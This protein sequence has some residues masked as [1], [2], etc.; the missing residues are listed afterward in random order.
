MSR[1]ARRLVLPLALLLSA[2]A[3]VAQNH[4]NAD[5]G[6]APERA[7]QVG[8]IDNVSLF[9]GNLAI[10]IPLGG[11]YPAG[12]G[13]SY[14]LTLVYNSSVW[15]FQE[16]LTPEGSLTQA[17]PYRHSNAGFGWIVSLGRLYKPGDV[18]YDGQRW[19]YFGVDGAEHRFYPTLHEGD[20]E[21]AGD[22]SA[23]QKVQYS[24]EGSY[25]RLKVLAGGEHE[26]EFPDG[27][28]H[29]FGTDRKLKQIRDRFNN[30]VDVATTNALWT[31]TDGQG[32]IHRVHFTT[33]QYDT[34][35]LPT[36]DRVELQTFAGTATY[37]FGYS[38]TTVTRACPHNDT[39][40]LGTT[41][42]VPLLTSVSL[43]DDPGQAVS[44]YQYVM[45]VGDYLTTV[46]R[47]GPDCRKA[48]VLQGLRLPSRGRLEWSYQDYRF[49]TGS[50]RPPFQTTAGVSKRRMIDAGGALLGE[51]TYQTALT[52][53]QQIVPN[54]GTQ[55]LINTVID[56]LGHK[57]V[58]YFS[59]HATTTPPSDWTIEDYSL[60]FTRFDAGDGAGRFL[61]TRTFNSAGTLLRSTYVR[62][63]RDQ[64]AALRP[65]DFQDKL[66]LNRRPETERT[67]YHDDSNRFADTTFSEFDGLGNQRKTTTGGNF[68]EGNVRATT[69]AYNPARGIYE[70]DLASNAPAPGHTFT[71]LSKDSP[72]VLDTYASQKVEEAGDAAFATFCFDAGTGFLQRKRVLK[73]PTGVEDA[74]DLLEA[75]VP[76]TRPG[77]GSSTGDVASERFYGGDTQ[78]LATS[79]TLCSIGLPAVPSYQ[80]DHTYQFGVKAASQYA[81]TTFKVFDQDIHPSGLVTASRDSAGLAT[82]YEYD[83]QG[84][85]TW[86][87][88][89]QGHGGWTEYVYSPALSAGSLANVL[90]RQ[91]GNGIKTAPILVQS[92]VFVDAFGRL[93]R[94][95]QML[96]GGVWNTRETLYNASG[97]KKSDSELQVGNPTSV[98]Q[99]LDY[100]PFGR[101]QTI[102]PPDGTAHD[103]AFNYFGIRGVDRI[104]KVAVYEGGVVAEKPS[105]TTEV[106]DRQGR[107]VKV[108]EPSAGGTTPVPTLYTYDIGNRLKQVSTT[109]AGTTQNRFFNYDNRGFLTSE[110]HP[111][112]TGAVSYLLYDAR[113]HA[114]RK[115]DGPNDLALVYDKAER[116]TDVR[117]WSSN[118]LLKKLTYAGANGANDWRAG[119]LQEASRYNFVS[120]GATPYTVQIRES[121]TYGGRDGRVSRRDTASI[122]NGAAGDS[123]TQ[124]FSYNALGLPATVEYPICTHAGCGQPAPA[125]FTDVPQGHPAKKEIEAIYKAKVTLGCATNPARYC[126]EGSVTRAEMAL[127]LVRAAA[128]GD[129]VPPACGTPTFSDVPCGHWASAWIEE[130]YRRGITSGCDTNPL[131]YCPESWVA[132]PEMMIFLLR[133]KEGSTYTAPACTAPTF[134]D[135]TCGHWAASWIGEAA[136]RGITTGCGSGNFCP[137]GL[138]SRS[139]M[140]GYLTLAFDFPVVVDPL[141]PRTVQ[142]AY[143]Q[144]LL[145][146][147]GVPGNASLYGSLSYHPNLL[148][149][150]V[151]HGNGVVETQGNDPSAIRRPASLGASG[152]H[153]SWSS[154]PYSYD[155]ARNVKTI[156]T[157]WFG[158]DRVSRLTIGTV[159]DG[160][161]GGGS[162]KQQT[163]SFDPF[164]NLTAVGGAGGR[165]V[166]VNPATN[167]LNGGGTNYDGAGNL[168]TWNGAAYGY[169]R[170]NQMTSM[171]S[172]AEDW[173][174]LYTADDERIWSY[175]VSA[176]FSRWTIRGLGGKVLRE[177]ENDKGAWSVASDSI[178]RDSQLLAAETDQGRRHYHLDHLG[179]PRLIT[180]VHGDKAAYHV[181]Y[182]FGEE[183]TAFNQDTERMKFTGHERD[184]ASPAGPGD[185]LDYMHARFFSPV[186]G[187]FLSVDPERGHP[188]DPK[189][190][191]RYAYTLG[192]PIR[193]VD[194]DGQYADVV[195]L[196]GVATAVVIAA[197]HATQMHTNEQYRD[198]VIEG[199]QRTVEA[200][201]GTVSLSLSKRTDNSDGSETIAGGAK[202]VD[203][204]D[205]GGRGRFQGLS[206]AVDQLLGVSDAQDRSRQGK[207]AGHLI[208]SIEKSK[209]RVQNELD[210]IVALADTWL[211]ELTDGDDE[212]KDNGKKDEPKKK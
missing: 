189:S 81:G 11:S 180:D 146:G 13:L 193:F 159:F 41:A 36:V 133:A 18:G 202:P 132:N 87:M 94:A 82:A 58:R 172:G 61:S 171:T 97:L 88:P 46:N 12:G 165:A 178:Y 114:G 167:R 160:P 184:F 191:N 38:Q 199:G 187:R 183:A 206:D 26:V 137:A 198:K 201:S 70:I 104:S 162:Q 53:P 19:A 95:S 59:V 54:P 20:A 176:D 101:A 32:R 153:A 90:V 22:T 211:D 34:D 51:W 35:F 138:V 128:G 127:F 174:Y 136:R 47:T 108:S 175:N 116:L 103:T 72:W 93:W 150:Q 195:V 55:E 37:R 78:A 141:T 151:S 129:F 210:R 2:T 208:D 134:T 1:T 212:K 207:A 131:R 102:R 89:G 196:S 57:T 124:G 75:Y 105:T 44:R 149:N 135:V 80:L 21:D 49:P 154:G 119:K 86:V 48:G 15:D 140:A 125:V 110:T 24:R 85:P 9:N 126:P 185:D 67:V 29:R 99:F 98:T 200:V 107:L 157:S 69:T 142:Y 168:I 91:R 112:K 182:P 6:F 147:V 96:P 16:S 117:E 164:G 71:M 68:P 156:G 30:K 186:T 192:N 33:R 77:D 76:E 163:Y 40:T 42:S 155:G 63:E 113:G 118:Q 66:N 169:D 166:P 152:P 17:R 106:Y 181:Y 170:L 92:Q 64:R 52:P 109:A 31:L 139:A 4:P 62:Y 28:I 100:D 84:R 74:A 158:Y 205:R 45:A 50:G 203:K 173:R 83:L 79:G 56:P 145:T 23:N 148:V 177:Y 7:F 3:A 43:P 144:G 179:S 5:R 27:Q 60:P 10:T 115:T 161:T 120:I 123:F 65:N 194:P 25:L 143:G 121:Y 190:W 122:V 130:L 197:V 111:E 14:S 188:Q 73:R 209:Q 204:G 39:G 8:E